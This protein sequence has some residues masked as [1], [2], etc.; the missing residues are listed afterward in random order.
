M[1]I[2][3]G[4]LNNSRLPMNDKSRDLIVV[5]AGTYHVKKKKRVPTLRPK[6]RIDYQLVYIASGKAHFYFNGK[7]T[8]V[9]AGHMV[10][11]LPREEQKYEYFGDDKTEAYWVHFTGAKVKGIMRHFD[12]PYNEPFFYSG[13]SE[14]YKMLFN[15]M[16]HELRARPVGYEEMIEMNL[17]Q[18]F[19][20]I[21]RTRLERKPQINTFA[22][23][24]V[25][26]ARKYFFEHYSEDINISEFAQSRHMSV[27]WFM[28]NFK[29]MTGVSPM[30]YIL[31]LRIENAQMLLET[32]N[33]SVNEI[34]A[35]VGY[36]NQLYF[37]RLFK[38][39][40]GIAPTEFRK[41]Q[42]K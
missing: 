2:N 22:Q 29:Q 19:M 3:E 32:T 31:N 12:I 33:Y 5:S 18:M 41:M 1:Y 37:S 7:D 23:A 24:E 21:Q 17:R 27:S 34:S 10:V 38:K 26:Y 42:Q 15:S 36:D 11:Y 20:T 30:Q 9:T 6:G 13:S 8:T 39:V 28:R 14:E 40:K 16:I 25:G 4:Y 35:I